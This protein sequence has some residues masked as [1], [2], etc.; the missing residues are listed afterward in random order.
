MAKGDFKEGRSKVEVKCENREEVGVVTAQA[1]IS[2]PATNR[3]SS[4]RR[5]EGERQ[6][7]RGRRIKSEGDGV[8]V[9]K[10]W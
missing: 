10:R 1:A 2:V 8:G 9:G 3:G 7:G 5:R 4:R 6:R